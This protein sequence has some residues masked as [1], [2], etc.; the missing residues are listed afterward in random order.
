[1]PD[2]LPRLASAAPPAT[3]IEGI[4]RRM[5]KGLGIDRAIA[6]TVAGR[7]WSMGAGVGTVLLIARFLTPAQQ[8]YYYTFSSLVALQVF[9]ELGFSFVVLQLAS[10]ERA[11]LVISE[12]GP[13]I[14]DRV[15][16][17]RLASILQTSLR[18]YS[19]MAFLMACTLLPAG[20]Y[21]F[22]R[23]DHRLSTPVGWQAP[24]CIMALAASFNLLVD[25]VFSFFEGCGLVSK[26][27][28][29]R[30]GQSVLG[31]LLAWTALISGHG[32]FAPPMILLGQI[33]WGIT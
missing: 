22:H 19:A 14:G 24:W 3:G 26:V 16:Q 4:L 8:G 12:D 28:H 5:Q 6:W 29:M 7:F 10:H 2:G 23:Q 15:S 33:S 31:S 13:V 18:W 21:F 27:A 32:L 30:F 25:P 17:A 20:L 11:S 1:M 9:F